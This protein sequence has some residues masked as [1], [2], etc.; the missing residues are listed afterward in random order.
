MH[1]TSI[2]DCRK[3]V[4]IYDVK[5]SSPN[6][7]LKFN[8]LYCALYHRRKWI[9]LTGLF[10][11]GGWEQD[12]RCELSM[13]SRV[14]YFMHRVITG[15]G[16]AVSLELSC[17]SRILFQIRGFLPHCHD[18]SKKERPGGSAVG[19]FEVRK[20]KCKINLWIESLLLRAIML[21]MASTLCDTELKVSNLAKHV[22]FKRDLWAMFPC[23]RTLQDH[24]D[25]SFC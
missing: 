6:K 19:Q 14:R 15:T 21:L 23:C 5:F 17:W 1:L 18:I 25:L 8:F 22:L 16:N 12:V 10:I 7:T 11:S 24:R 2:L 4:I 9:R 13:R 3:R 20:A